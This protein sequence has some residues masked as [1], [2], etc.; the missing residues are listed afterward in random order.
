[1]GEAERHAIALQI[2]RSDARWIHDELERFGAEA[3]R[4][5]RKDENH[6]ALLA[7]LKRLDS[8][9]RAARILSSLRLPALKRRKS[10]DPS[11]R[12]IG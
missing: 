7:R 1:M 4:L 12:S 8:N 6:A 2:P 3:E 11:P 10:F 9:L 5:R